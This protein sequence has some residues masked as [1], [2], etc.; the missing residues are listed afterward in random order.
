MS[1]FTISGNILCRKYQFSLILTNYAE[2]ICVN[3]VR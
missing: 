2:A 1:A 3:V